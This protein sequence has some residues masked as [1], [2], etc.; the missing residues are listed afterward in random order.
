MCLALPGR[1][2]WIGKGSTSSIPATVSFGERTRDVDLVMVP[3][4]KVGDSVIVHSG[5]AIRIV[6]AEDVARILE[7]VDFR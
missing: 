1:I 4:A 3:E 5:Y 6:S 7:L 2:E